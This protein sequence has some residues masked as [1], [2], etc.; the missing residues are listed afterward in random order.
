MERIGLIAGNGTF[1]ILF[2]REAKARG[3]EVVAVAHSGETLPALGDEVDSVCW[4]RV[5]QIGRMIREFK[6]RGVVRAVMA[7]GIDKAGSLFSFRPDFRALRL[8]AGARG[9][10]DDAILRKVAAEFEREGVQIVPSTLF[11]D[12]IVVPRGLLAGPA[13]DARACEDIRLGFRVLRATGQLDVGQGVV[14]EGGVVLAVEAIEGT[15]EAIRR[16]GAFA[17]GAAVVVKA[18]KRGQDMRFDVP[19][20]GPGTIEAM[21]AAG[22]R[23]LAVE[24]GAAIVLEGE[25]MAELSIRHGV[26]V[27]GCDADGS[28]ADE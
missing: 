19:A 11:L 9:K 10:G 16:A 6:R 25:K 15:D 14:V 26:G 24:A 1:P 20:V 13:P 22:A 7:G 5:G 3:C 28:F 23:T 27:V 21:R 2:A 12:R 18:A 4:V 8:L 17:R